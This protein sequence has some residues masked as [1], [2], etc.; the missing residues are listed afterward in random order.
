VA[1]RTFWGLLDDPAQAALDEAG[2]FKI[3]PDAHSLM[4]QGD[5]AERVYVLMEGAAKVCMVSDRGKETVL[6]VVGPGDIV[7]ELEVIDGR[8]R[9]ASVVAKGMIR[10]LEVPAE[11]FRTLTRREPAMGAA[12]LWVLCDRLRWSNEIRAARGARERVVELLHQIALRQGE[13]A[14]GFVAI[15]PRLSS[16]EFANWAGTS[17][18]S[19]LRALSWLQGKGVVRR[20]G[21]EFVVNLGELHKA[22]S[23]RPYGHPK[24]QDGTGAA[25]SDSPGR[26]SGT[27]R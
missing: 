6:D 12:L 8:P 16:E 3:V 18:G 23:R 5:R 10:V 20:A 14:D 1:D 24:G 26:W 19:A 17:R 13:P 2:H 25:S 22:L 4:I 15:K 7:G 27:K 11:R 9:V 21:H